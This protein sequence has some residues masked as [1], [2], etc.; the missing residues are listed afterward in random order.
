MKGL[1][2]AFWAESLKVRKSKIF[3]ITILIFSFIAVMMGLLVFIANHPEL[4]GD[5]VVLSAKASMIGDADWLAYFELLYQ[6]I[7][8]IGLLGFGF[9]ISW[10]FG[11]EYSDRT[12]KDMLALPVSRFTIVLSKFIVITIWVAMLS[13]ILF[14]LGLATGL[15]VN[16]PGWSGE[17]ALHAFFIFTGTS[18]LT[19][20]LCTPIAFFASYG[21]GYLLPMGFIILVIIITQFAII[22]IPGIA[23]YIP[24]AIPALF[25]GAAGPSGPQ[26]GAVSYI[27]LFFT[28]ILGLLITYAWWRFADHK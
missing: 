22:G 3:W 6:L 7:A 11:R 28:S 23:P 8:M 26:I 17:T 13:L 16:I 15:A 27:I 2:N 14:V 5:S 4:V 25:C 24:W 12:I 10:V 21:R 20:L 18:I 19:L 9:V 1:Y